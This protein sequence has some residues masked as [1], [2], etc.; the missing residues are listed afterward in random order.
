VTAKDADDYRESVVDARAGVWTLNVYP[1][2]VCTIRRVIILGADEI[3][4]VSAGMFTLMDDGLV[5]RQGLAEGVAFEPKMS[6]RFLIG[7][8]H[9]VKAVVR[10]LV[11]RTITL[12]VE[13]RN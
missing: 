2:S 8:W 1:P 6:A 10:T 4:E 13:P 5:A 3:I 11:D 12:I 9:G 7:G